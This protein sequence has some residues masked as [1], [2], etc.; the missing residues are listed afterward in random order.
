MHGRHG[1]FP[2]LRLPLDS[3][4]VGLHLGVGSGS[5]AISIS[6]TAGS[7]PEANE[8]MCQSVILRSQSGASDLQIT[9]SEFQANAATSAVILQPGYG[10]R[11]RFSGDT[12]RTRSGTR[13]VFL[14]N[15]SGVPVEESQT[16]AG[17]LLAAGGLLGSRRGPDREPQR[18]RPQLGGCG[19]LPPGGRSV[20]SGT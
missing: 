18:I 17:G 6:I 3:S 16:S 9:N 14:K 5:P 13:P 1:S 2:R 8:A 7:S 19:D 4:R 15:L 20:P 12:F 11:A 10:G